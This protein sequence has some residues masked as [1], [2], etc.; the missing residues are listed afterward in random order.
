MLADKCQ[1]Q[2][3]ASA[4]EMNVQR[5]PASTLTIKY[6]VPFVLE[7]IIKASPLAIVAVDAEDRVILWNESAERL[8]GWN[9]RD[10]L[11]KGQPILPPAGEPL[12]AGT[13]SHPGSQHGDES[14]RI[15]KNGSRVPVSIWTAAISNNGGTLTVFADRTALREAERSRADLVESERSARESAIAARRF[16]LLLEA[17]PDAILEIDP[18]RPDCR[19]EYRGRAAVSAV[20]RGIDRIAGGSIAAGAIS[21][22]ARRASRSITASIRCAG[23]WAPVWIYLPCA[24]TAPSSPSI[25]I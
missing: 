18:A 11:G 4:M 7:A 22:R 1:I 15:H 25:S 24:R 13:G 17:A 21:R 16:S 19:G 6:Q 14:V 8:F 5:V 9:E 23:P 10:V 12:Q 3:D 2:G 20:A